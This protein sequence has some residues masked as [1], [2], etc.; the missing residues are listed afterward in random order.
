VNL[1]VAPGGLAAESAFLI[2]I[3]GYSALDPGEEMRQRGATWFE[4]DDGS[5]V[6]LSEDPDHQPA[7]RAHVAVAYGPGLSDVRERLTAAAWKFAQFD[8]AA[9]AQVILCKDPAGNRWE[10][11]GVSAS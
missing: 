4:A 6:H 3:L 7:A 5:Q 10:L 2:E 11:R 9:P 8:G 1:G